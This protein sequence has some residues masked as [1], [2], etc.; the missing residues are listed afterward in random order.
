MCREFK[1]IIR[2]VRLQIDGRNGARNGQFVRLG[3]HISRYNFGLERVVFNFALSTFETQISDG[4]VLI[5]L[6]AVIGPFG[7]LVT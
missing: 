4:V 2:R 6:D 5:L 3:T 1:F 7:E